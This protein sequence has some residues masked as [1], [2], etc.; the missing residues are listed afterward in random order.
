MLHG[1]VD[2]RLDLVDIGHV[3]APERHG[4]AQLGGQRFA[5][6]DGHVGD[7]DLG[8]FAGEE[9][10]GGPADPARTSGDDGDLPR[11]FV[12]HIRRFLSSG[13]RHRAMIPA[14]PC[15]AVCCLGGAATEHTPGG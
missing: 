13:L 12:A 6:L 7:D 14:L 2:Q 5:L 9:L 1:E 8:A 15:G 10:D 4:I 3:G 11:Q